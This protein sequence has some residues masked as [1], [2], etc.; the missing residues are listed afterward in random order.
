M[1]SQHRHQLQQNDLGQ[2]ALQA[3]PWLE[4]HG[5]KLIVAVTVLVVAVIGASV[6]VN[7][8]SHTR[9]EAWTKLAGAQTVD[10]FGKVAD[11]FPASLAGAWSRLRMGEMNLE[12]GIAALFTDRELAVKDL[13]AAR[14]DFDQVLSSAVD[15]PDNLRERAMFGQARCVEALSDGDTT[16]AVEAYQALLTRF[17][18][19][20]YKTQVEE[21]IKEL[22]SPEAKQFYGWFHKQTPK[23]PALPRPNDGAAKPVEST[24]PG[25]D[26]FSLPSPS[27]SPTT[28]PAASGTES[29]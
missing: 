2:I 5:T 23:P 16:A 20:I 1:D 14:K 18:A 26:P 12:S 28:E 22:Q 29:K 8:R 10:E 21:R 19:S 17:P 13:E 27:E 7:A 15:L 6:W 3:K 4:Q 24:T 11:E 25:G 9:S